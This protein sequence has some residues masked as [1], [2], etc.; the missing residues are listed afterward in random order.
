VDGNDRGPSEG[1]APASAWID[2]SKHAQNKIRLEQPD[3]GSVV[4]SE[5][6]QIPTRNI[7][8][9]TAMFCEL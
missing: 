5:G 1:A 2:C 3:S 7:N 4:E 9:Y 8:H 6:F